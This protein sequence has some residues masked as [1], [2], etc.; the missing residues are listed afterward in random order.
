M[1]FSSFIFRVKKFS[2]TADPENEAATVVQ[3]IKNYLLIDL[4]SYPRRLESLAKPQ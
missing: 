4:E 3:N 2:M 1:D